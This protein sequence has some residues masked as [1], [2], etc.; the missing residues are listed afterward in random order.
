MLMA[1]EL[2][3]FSTVLLG[4]LFLQG[5]PFVEEGVFPDQGMNT[6]FLLFV[7]EYRDI[8]CFPCHGSFLDFCA[9]L[10]LPIQR[11]RAW[12]I[13]VFEPGLD[14]GREEKIIARKVRGFL[15]GNK[16]HVPV[17]L[18]RLHLFD[19]MRIQGSY[20]VLCDLTTMSVLS[21]PFPLSEKN[22]KEILTTILNWG[23]SQ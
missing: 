14:T 19:P 5:I 21:Y 9:S 20:V 10:P 22:K 3:F 15:T 11:E 2:D 1:K 4:V 18:D 13:V 7:I 23:P 17:S 16:I 12:G 8:L 6:K